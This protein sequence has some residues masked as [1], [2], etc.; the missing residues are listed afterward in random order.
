VIRRHPDIKLLRRAG[1][2]AAFAARQ[3]ELLRSCWPLLRPGGRLLYVTCSVLPAETSDVVAA[4]V[5]EQTG[6][7]ERVLSGAQERCPPLRRCRYGWQ[8]LPGAAGDGFY[9]ACLS[10][11]GAP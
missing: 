4:L 1:D 10:H 9:Y 6:V 11:K 2:I 5:A 8:V 7:G 3:R